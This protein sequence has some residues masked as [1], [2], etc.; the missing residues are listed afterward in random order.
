MIGATGRWLNVFCNTALALSQALE[1]ASV[2]RTKLR[3]TKWDSA[4]I[5]KYLILR[6]V[7]SIISDTT[8]A[9]CA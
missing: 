1:L 6:R 2:E 9:A 8:V 3:A 4:V 7:R 5:G